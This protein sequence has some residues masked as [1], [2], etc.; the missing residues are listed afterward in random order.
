MTRRPMDKSFGP[1]NDACRIFLLLASD[2]GN[3]EVGCF[4][5]TEL[6]AS[7][8][9]ISTHQLIEHSWCKLMHKC[10]LLERKEILLHITI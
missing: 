3:Y 10:G 8:S 9:A 4:L 5:R 7:S 6:I 1:I 2:N